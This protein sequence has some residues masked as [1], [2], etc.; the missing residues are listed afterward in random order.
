MNTGSY[1]E[2]IALLESIDSSVLRTIKFHQYTY[3]CI[4]LIKL[5]RS[6]RHTDWSACSSLLQSLNP[7]S[8]TDP[9]C[10]FLLS[11]AR[12]DYLSS[13]GLFSDAFNAIEDMA[14]SLREE[15]T[16]ILPR[17]TM[18]LMKANLFAKIGKP[19]RGFS[20]ALRAASVAFK[21]R[22]MPALWAAVGL[23]SNILN[24]LGEFSASSRLLSA[25]IPQTLEHGDQVLIGTLYSHLG[26]SHIGL[27][28]LDNPSTSSGARA[29]TTNMSNAE[30]YFDRARECWKKAEDIEGEC[31]QLMKRAIVAKARGDEKLAE[32]WSQNH[33]RVWEEGR[34]RIGEGEIVA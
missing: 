3:F 7:D 29:R 31:E 4:G 20:V 18:L 22:L 11:E 27:A 34:R 12:I 10:S 25:I 1:D 21:A 33:N 17:V 23:L 32:E 26:D 6:I 14:S 30:L 15:G 13:R 8:S 16:D 2:G 9:E 24:S 19:D 28:G 5:K